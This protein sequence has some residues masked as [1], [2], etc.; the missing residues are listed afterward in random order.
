MA[1]GPAYSVAIA[2]C[3]LLGMYFIQESSL[4]C[5][6]GRPARCCPLGYVGLTQGS[7]NA[8]A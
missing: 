8:I 7:S 6:K 4:C 1:I 2:A 5:E 3:R